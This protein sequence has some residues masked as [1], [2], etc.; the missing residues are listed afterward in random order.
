MDLKP[1]KEKFTQKRKEILAWLETQDNLP[2]YHIRCELCLDTYFK[3]VYR[4]GIEYIARCECRCGNDY[5][6]N[7]VALINSI[8]IA[9]AID[10]TNIEKFNNYLLTQFKT[11]ILEEIS[12]DDLFRI[13]LILKRRIIDNGK[14][15]ELNRRLE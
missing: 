2:D 10:N 9:L 7:T 11:T 1:Y 13:F 4:G 12:I 14:G 15:L 3:V 6:M 8:N 5:A